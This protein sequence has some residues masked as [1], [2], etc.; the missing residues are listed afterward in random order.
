MPNYLLI[1][2]KPANIVNVFR[3]YCMYNIEN[4]SC[5]ENNCVASDPLRKWLCCLCTSDVS[6]IK[7]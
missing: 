7:L 6:S 3:L 2:T 1:T 5:I 4:E